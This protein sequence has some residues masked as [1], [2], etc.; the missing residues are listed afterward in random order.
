[1]GAC[2]GEYAKQ[3]GLLRA[4]S[5]WCFPI[6]Q[7]PHGGIRVLK[8]RRRLIICMLMGRHNSPHSAWRLL[9]VFVRDQVWVREGGGRKEGV[10]FLSFFKMTCTAVILI[11]SGEVFKLCKR[12]YYTLSQSCLCNVLFAMPGP[13]FADGN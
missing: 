9:C 13:D 6:E 8:G 12:C 7:K 2:H 11:C 10:F 1:M 4:A 3:D 5:T